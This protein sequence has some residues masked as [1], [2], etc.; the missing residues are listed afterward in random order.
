MSEIYHEASKPHERLM[1]NVAIF[2]FFVPA[3]LFGTRNL[4]LIFSLSL[5]GSL[6]MIGS[7]AY[8][9]YNSQDQTALVQAHWKLAWKRCWYLLGAYLV[10]AV[11]F[12]LGS[13]LLMSQADESMRFIQRSV[14]GWFALVPISLTLIALIVLEGSALVQARK[15]VMPSEMKL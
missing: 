12:G 4:W 5:L 14:L 2:H 9:A 10:A 6:V 13:F 1:F 7:I 15:G 11:I 3:I 8:K